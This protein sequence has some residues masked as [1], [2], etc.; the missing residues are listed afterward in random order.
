MCRNDGAYESDEYSA[1]ILRQSKDNEIA[2]WNPLEVHEILLLNET[3]RRDIHEHEAYF[4]ANCLH[5][6]YTNKRN[7]TI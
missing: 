7:P 4:T 3:D 2:H 6:M 1:Y 5:V